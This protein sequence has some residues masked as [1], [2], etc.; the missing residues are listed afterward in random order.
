MKYTLTEEEEIKLSLQKETK[1]ELQKKERKKIDYHLDDRNLKS[2]PEIETTE[3]GKVTQM[4]GNELHLRRIAT[5]RKKGKIYKW[6][7]IR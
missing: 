2:K 1:L 5:I 3:K 7:L 6:K 4:N